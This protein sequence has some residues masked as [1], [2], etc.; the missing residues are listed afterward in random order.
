MKKRWELI[1]II[2]NIIFYIAII[3]AFINPALNS[4]DTILYY[5]FFTAI[6]GIILVITF[7]KWEPETW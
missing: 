4:G 5:T 7:W 2:L 1:F 3:P 6:L